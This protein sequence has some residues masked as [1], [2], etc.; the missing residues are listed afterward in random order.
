MRI[1][2]LDECCAFV[3]ESLLP[4][5]SMPPKTNHKKVVERERKY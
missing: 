2:S 4:A 1:F 5:A 3:S